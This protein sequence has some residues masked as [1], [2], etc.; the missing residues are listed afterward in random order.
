VDT[1]LTGTEVRFRLW[2]YDLGL[3]LFSLFFAGMTALAVVTAST[4][5]GRVAGG[6][7]MGAGFVLC[8]GAWVNIRLHP[9]WLVV[10]NDLITLG[11]RGRPTTTSLQKATSAELG[12]VLV[13][14]GRG[15]HWNLV[16]AGSTTR[17]D[18]QGFKKQDV[19]V[20]CLSHGWHFGG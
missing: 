5:G 3:G 7:L 6:T 14:Y 9:A 16:Q 13:R 18:I 10:D 4:A 15:A 11:A 17:L 19:T 8:I 2:Q 1:S 20:A 12:Y